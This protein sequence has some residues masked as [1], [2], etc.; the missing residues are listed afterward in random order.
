MTQKEKEILSSETITPEVIDFVTQ[1]IV[2]LFSPEKVIMFGSQARGESLADSDLDLFIVKDSEKGNLEM[3]GDINISFWGRR[4]PL[5][6]V[7]RKPK[8]IEQSNSEFLHTIFK[9]GVILYGK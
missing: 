7:V 9:E 5:D 1:R 3:E 8:E 6:I 4:F 2:H